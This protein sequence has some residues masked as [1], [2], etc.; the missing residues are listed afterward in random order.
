MRAGNAGAQTGVPGEER[1]W[2]S[3]EALNE[4]YYDQLMA[5]DVQVCDTALPRSSLYVLP[6]TGP[7]LLPHFPLFHRRTLR[8]SAP[9]CVPRACKHVRMVC[10][11]RI[12][13]SV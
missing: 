2:S 12:L 8:Q 1:V 13:T 10:Q 9:K 7:R 6:S 3:V 11:E 5:V 4:L